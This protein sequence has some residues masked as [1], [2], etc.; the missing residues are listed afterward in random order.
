MR[1]LGSLSTRRYV[2]IARDSPD[3]CRERLT[4]A[5]VSWNPMHPVLMWRRVPVGSFW[6]RVSGGRFVIARVFRG[7]DTFYTEARGSFHAQMG[8]LQTTRIE[9]SIGMNRIGKALLGVISA[10]LVCLIV[11]IL[12]TIV[13]TGPSQGNMFVLAVS[14][15]ILLR[16]V[17]LMAYAGRAKDASLLVAFLKETLHTPKEP[18]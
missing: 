15:L 17:V 9:V 5:L 2:L 14:L 13:H 18:S 12:I 6:G 7:R 16:M 10:F 3:Q 8:G 11:A 4:R 1:W